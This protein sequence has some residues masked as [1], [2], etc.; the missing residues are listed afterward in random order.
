M[1][2]PSV[3]DL[4]YTIGEIPTDLD[5]LYRKII[6]QIMKGSPKVQ[7]LLV[8]VVYA[9]QPLMLNELEAALATQI[10]SKDKRSTDDHR[11]DLTAEEVTSASRGILEVTDNIVHLI[12]QSAK[13][14]LQQQKLSCTTICSGMDPNLYLAKV[15]MTYLNFDDFKD[16]P[17]G[18]EQK[19]ALRKSEYPF[20]H[21][22]AQNWHTHIRSKDDIKE[23]SS[24]LNQ[25]IEPRSST[26]LSWG[27]AAEIRSLDT[28]DNASEIAKRANV[29]WLAEFGLSNTK[30]TAEIVE[31]AAK[32]WAKEYTMMEM[33]IRGGNSLFI[34]IIIIII[35]Y[36]SFLRKAP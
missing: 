9:Q 8:W 28:A 32:N 24:L 23:I 11:S 5:E 4:K 36:I 20:F 14:F 3:A 17:C 27:E 26:L 21:Y 25:L 6:E 19:L 29:V 18:T 7:K 16:G 31:N 15:C 10:D 34:I 33:L 1:D 13:D 30:I 35:S 2:L 12:H 22:A